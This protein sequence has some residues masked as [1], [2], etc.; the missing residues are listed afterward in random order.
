MPVNYT[1]LIGSKCL[2]IP[3]ARD[4]DTLT[5]NLISTRSNPGEYIA[6][7]HL[8]EN[9]SMF[10]KCTADT[11]NPF[12]ACVLYMLSNG[13]HESELNYPFRYFNLLNHPDAILH[14][15]QTYLNNYNVVEL[16]KNSYLP[17]QFYHIVYQYY[18]ILENTHWIS[19][20]G[21]EIVQKIHDF[22]MPASYFYELK[23]LVNNL[24]IKE[25]N[26]E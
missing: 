16:E 14:S 17:K 25:N 15:I 2:K 20:E 7:K 24:S 18:M 13:F 21:R 26:N 9:I 12:S 10:C 23:D 8:D 11:Y 3:N 6:K 22:Q 4:V 5:V 19:D 1:I